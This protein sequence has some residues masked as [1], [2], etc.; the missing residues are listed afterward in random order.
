[1]KGIYMEF[2]LYDIEAVSNAELNALRTLGIKIKLDYGLKK[3]RIVED[4]SVLEHKDCRL[5]E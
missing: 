3:V 5:K 4:T 2:D 1:M